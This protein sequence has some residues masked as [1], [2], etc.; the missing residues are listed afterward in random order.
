M[1]TNDRLTALAC[2]ITS[3]LWIG[4]AIVGGDNKD[5]TIAALWGMVGLL[6][7]RGAK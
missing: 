7:W 2:F 5:L 4:S 3:A 6:W 1:S